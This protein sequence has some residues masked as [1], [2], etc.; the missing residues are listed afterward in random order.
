[1]HEAPLNDML[2]EALK[3]RPGSGIAGEPGPNVDAIGKAPM[4]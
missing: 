3:G 4:L 2:A 1:M